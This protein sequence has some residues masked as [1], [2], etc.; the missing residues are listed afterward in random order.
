MGAKFGKAEILVN[1]GQAVMSDDEFRC[2]QIRLTGRYKRRNFFC[3]A[4]LA[5]RRMHA[6]KCGYYE[7]GG[8]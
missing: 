6:A 2:N 7:A 1:M 3:V 4:V 8:E 5:S